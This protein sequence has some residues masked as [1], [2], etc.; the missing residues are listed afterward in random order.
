MTVLLLQLCTIFLSLITFYRI[1]VVIYMP[2][3]F[4]HDLIGFEGGGLSFLSGFV[5][6]TDDFVILS[7]TNMPPS[8]MY[9]DWFR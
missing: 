3:L 6:K 1:L 8:L 9:H 5:M 7:V 4:T 2:L